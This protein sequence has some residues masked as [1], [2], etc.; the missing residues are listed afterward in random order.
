MAFWDTAPQFSVGVWVILTNVGSS[1]EVM[2]HQ[3]HH[4][5]YWNMGPFSGT[6]AARGGDWFGHRVTSLQC[7][8][9]VAC[10]CLESSWLPRSPLL[11]GWGRVAHSWFLS[12]AVIAC[13]L[14]ADSNG[15]F[16]RPQETG[17]AVCTVR[18]T[19]YWVS[20]V[21]SERQGSHSG[22][23]FCC[24]GKM[25]ICLWFF[26]PAFLGFVPVQLMLSLSPWPVCVC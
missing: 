18:L 15:D 9:S 14:L 12:G 7:Q 19:N 22:Y 16:E 26:F 23:L 4:K 24:V 1:A 20:P 21:T 8:I 6:C 5:S 13:H 3:I 11:K 10:T 25:S 2:N 17:I